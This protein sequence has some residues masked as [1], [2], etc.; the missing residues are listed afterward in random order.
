M[1]CETTLTWWW[2]N[3]LNKRRYEILKRTFATL[4]D[5]LRQLD[6]PMLRGLGLKQ[7]T[8]V[9]TL[10]RLQAFDAHRT[11]AMLLKKG[12]SVCS[13]E[14]HLYPETLRDIPDAPIFLSW[15]GDLSIANHPSVSVVGTRRMS[16]YGRRLVEAFVPRLAR[17]GCMTVSGLALGIDSAVAR[18]TIDATGKTIAVLGHGLS[19]IYPR[20]NER[21]ATKIVESGGLIM[22]EFSFDRQPDVY[23]FPAR[24]R[25]VAGL[26]LG[27]LV[28][29]AP[30]ES[31]AL[32]TARLALDYGR[33]VFAVPGL[34]FDDN[35]AGC[36]RLI[37]D[38]HAQLV[39]TPE[40]ILQ[41]LGMVYSEDAS[42]QS[43]VFF[44]ENAEQTAVYAVI[45]AIPQSVDDIAL[46]ANVSASGTA[47]ALT[48]ME[49]AG[50]VRNVGGGQWVR[51]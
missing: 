45:S 44:P 13:I 6:A 17:A 43:V 31:G 37:A 51:R 50:A 36:H 1:L 33:D 15:M 27:T 30:K 12:V 11:E 22:S 42:T 49:L 32:I 40:D 19:A 34:A 35:M 16:A 18:D 25:I 26:S 7:E 8:V 21:L 46:C 4:D 3:I 38:G 5:A 29:E 23:T 47:I 28:V 24:N 48:L 39:I 20:T 41:S 14:D 2:L 9:L 10:E